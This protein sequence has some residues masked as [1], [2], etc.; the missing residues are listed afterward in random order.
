M[1]GKVTEQELFE[2]CY[3]STHEAADAVTGLLQVGEPPAA[4][5][6]EKLK[7]LR[8]SSFVRYMPVRS[9][10]LRSADLRLSDILRQHISK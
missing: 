10:V 8:D 7:R 5:D 6:P 1:A 2:R 4:S 9:A 3:A